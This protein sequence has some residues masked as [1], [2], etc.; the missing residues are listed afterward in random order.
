MIYLAC[1]YTH[2]DPAVRESRYRAVTEMAAMLMA[3]KQRL[4]YSP[5]SHSHGMEEF[6][7]PIEYDFWRRHARWLIE[8]CDAVW[9][10]CIDGWR[11]SVGVAA[12]IAAAEEFGKPVCYLGGCGDCEENAANILSRISHVRP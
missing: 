1:P 5:I 11:E 6:G 7:L 12:E 4:I 3:S 8:R 2:P 10:Y 9:V